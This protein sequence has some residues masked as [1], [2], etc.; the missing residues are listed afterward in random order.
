MNRR[1]C[2]RRRGWSFPRLTPVWSRRM[3][4][5]RTA[6]GEVAGG[7]DAS[8]TTFHGSSLECRTELLIRRI[9][10][11]RQFFHL[12]MGTC[13]IE[14]RK[15]RCSICTG[16]V[17]EMIHR[18]LNIVLALL[19][20]IP[21]GICTC[22]AIDGSFDQHE[23]SPQSA[24]SCAR[25]LADVAPQWTNPSQPPHCVAAP[26]HESTCQANSARVLFSAPSERVSI[27]WVWAV[28]DLPPLMCTSGTT[29]PVVPQVVSPKLKSPLF[30]TYSRL[31][32]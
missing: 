17:D 7:C 16:L 10:G 22:S 28:C 11:P 2:H 23:D 15:V 19:M 27:I 31:L 18:I 26:R 25:G 21:S 14:L 32:I 20:L 30:L 8:R 29:C 6:F 1:R 9:R 12:S 3:P 24:R 4:R 5:G 13:R